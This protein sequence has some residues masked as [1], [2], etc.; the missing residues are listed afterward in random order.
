MKVKAGKIYKIYSMSM[1][2]YNDKAIRGDCFS[3]TSFSNK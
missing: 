3:K 1:K 2:E